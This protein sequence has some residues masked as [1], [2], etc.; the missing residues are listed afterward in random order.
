MENLSTASNI[1][2]VI[3]MFADTVTVKQ[4][5]LLNWKQ[6]LMFLLFLWGS[7]EPDCPAF[8]ILIKEY[9]EFPLSPALGWIY[10]TSA[11]F[12]FG[13]LWYFLHAQI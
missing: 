10:P 5:I 4:K 9:V 13:S 12:G 1:K 11:T 7:R 8:V 2:N 6:V 3:Q